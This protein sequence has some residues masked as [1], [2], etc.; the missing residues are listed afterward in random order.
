[1]MLVAYLAVVTI[2][3]MMVACWAAEIPGDTP[4]DEPFH[5]D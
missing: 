1:M 4:S 3:A 5:W 2:V